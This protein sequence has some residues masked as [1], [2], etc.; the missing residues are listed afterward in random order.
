MPAHFQ[1]LQVR[2]PQACVG[3]VIG[4]LSSIGSNVRS[5]AQTEPL[6]TIYVD[7]PLPEVLDFELWLDQNSQGQGRLDVDESANDDQA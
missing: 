5:L 3:A 1:K 7:M 2:V 4:K 6:H